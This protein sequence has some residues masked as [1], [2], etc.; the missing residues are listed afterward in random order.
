MLPPPRVQQNDGRT[1][2]R[3]IMAWSADCKRCYWYQKTFSKEEAKRLAREHDLISC[4]LYLALKR[5]HTALAD[6]A[7]RRKGKKE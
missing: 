1:T 5:S 4:D 2:V 7:V 3:A 6:R